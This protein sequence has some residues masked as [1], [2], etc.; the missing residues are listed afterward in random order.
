[1][2][3]DAPETLVRLQ[4]L[5]FVAADGNGVCSITPVETVAPETRLDLAMRLVKSVG[6]DAPVGENE[7][8]LGL[9]ADANGALWRLRNALK[10]RKE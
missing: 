7:P 5:A 1:M 2:T 4:D 3:P 8:V 6:D 9:A 10:D